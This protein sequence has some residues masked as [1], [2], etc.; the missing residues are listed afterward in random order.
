MIAAGIGDAARIPGGLRPG[1]MSIVALGRVL[2]GD[3]AVTL[4]D[5]AQRGL[6]DVAEINDSD[7][8]TTDWTVAPGSRTDPL[9]DY[10]QTLL[11]GLADY[12]E[13][14]RL[15]LLAAEFSLVLSKVR[16]K[17]IREAVHRGWLM[18]WHHDQRTPE[19][20]EL[21]R[22]LRAFR[23]GLRRLMAEQGADVL[24]RDWLPYALHFGLV[25]CD[26]IHLARFARSWV[27]A[28]KGLDSWSHI[29][30]RSRRPDEVIP[31]PKDEWRG[32]S[33]GLAAA[34]EMGI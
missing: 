1:Q 9:S 13:P 5:L 11:D 6:V 12:D 32:M 16:T 4:V 29:E 27:D 15:S 30:P 26:R 20:E 25:P 28:F 3:I 19:G 18:H 7:T 21:A 23:V 24:T 14:A 22:Q 17:L 31:F 8:A 2:M 33:L 34:W 10:E